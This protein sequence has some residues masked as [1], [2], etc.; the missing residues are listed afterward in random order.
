M[1]L[2]VPKLQE[3]QMNPNNLKLPY[4]KICLKENLTRRIAACTQVQHVKNSALLSFYFMYRILSR[5]NVNVSKTLLHSSL[6]SY[7]PVYGEVTRGLRI[8]MV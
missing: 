7:Q 8:S 3:N 5:I 1:T 6:E 4:A 2:N